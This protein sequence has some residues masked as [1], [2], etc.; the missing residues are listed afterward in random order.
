MGRLTIGHL[1]VSAYMYVYVC[2]SQYQ[3]E[4]IAFW[5]DVNVMIFEFNSNCCL[6]TLD[7]LARPWLTA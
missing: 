4:R 6:Q 3:N 7:R 1:I 2:V 5:S